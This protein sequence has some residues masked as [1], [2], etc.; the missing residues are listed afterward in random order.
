MPTPNK[1][2][3]ENI[4]AYFTKYLRIDLLKHCLFWIRLSFLMDQKF[5]HCFEKNKSIIN[6]LSLS[7]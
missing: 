5:L 4:E 6:I 3:K 7:L 1:P 2:T